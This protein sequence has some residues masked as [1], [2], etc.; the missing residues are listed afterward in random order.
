LHDIDWPGESMWKLWSPIDVTWIHYNQCNHFNWLILPGKLTEN[1]WSFTATTWG[2]VTGEMKGGR[3][4]KEGFLILETIETW[5]VWI[6]VPFRGWM[7]RTKDR[8]GFE[9]GMVIGARHTGFWKTATLVGFSH[10]T[11]SRV[12]Q[13]W[14][15]TQPTIVGSIGVNM[16]QHPCGMILIPCWVHSLTNWGCSE[17]QY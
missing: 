8:S 5:M 9:R 12:Y 15:T 6:C 4:V 13:V 3:Q 11:V 14:S 17:G 16:G 10:S 2:I 1:T 7:G